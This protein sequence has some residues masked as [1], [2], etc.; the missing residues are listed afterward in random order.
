MI[1]LTQLNK[2]NCIKTQQMY[3]KN[4]L[5]KKKLMIVNEEQLTN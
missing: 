3:L 4:L 2:N 5:D 1:I